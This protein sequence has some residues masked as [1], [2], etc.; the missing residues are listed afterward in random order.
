MP[1]SC[2]DGGEY[3]F[4]TGKGEKISQARRVVVIGGESIRV[5]GIVRIEYDL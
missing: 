3:Q 1:D 2:K 5:S 4:R